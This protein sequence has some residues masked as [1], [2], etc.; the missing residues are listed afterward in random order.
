MT[1]AFVERTYARKRL[2]RAKP[3][4]IFQLPEDEEDFKAFKESE[5]GKKLGD[6]CKPGAWIKIK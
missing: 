6:E 5:T 2:E 1:V 3:G 4:E